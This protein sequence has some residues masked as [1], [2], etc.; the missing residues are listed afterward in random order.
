MLSSEIFEQASKFKPNQNYVGPIQFWRM[1]ELWKNRKQIL[2]NETVGRSPKAPKTQI[3]KMFDFWRKQESNP[4][5]WKSLRKFQ[6]WNS[7]RDTRCSNQLWQSLNLEEG[8]NHS[9]WG[10]PKAE[11]QEK[12]QVTSTKIWKMFEFWRRQK[13]NCVESNLKM[14]EFW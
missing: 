6:S 8:K 9:V 10:S 11:T 5:E 1:F 2:L 13:S 7:G 14:L 4:V 3:W 12:L